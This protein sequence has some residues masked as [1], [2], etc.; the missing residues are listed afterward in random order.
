MFGLSKKKGGYTPADI[1]KK[2]LDLNKYRETL[3][4]GESDK[5]AK[6]SAER[7]LQNII[8]KLGALAVAQESKKGFPQGIPAVAR[9]YMEAYGIEEQ[10]LVPQ[11]PN[12][13]MGQPSPMQS[14]VEEVPET[15]GEQEDMADMS[16]EMQQQAPQ[17][18]PPE[19]QQQMMQQEQPT[20]AMYGAIMGGYDMPF[21]YAYGGFPKFAPGG[22]TPYERARTAAGNVTPTGSDNKYS[23]T[24]VPLAQHLADWEQYIPGVSNMSDGDAQKAMYEWSLKNNPDV[25]RQMWKARGI[26][27]EGRKYSDLMGLTQNGTG[28]FDDATLA[29]IDNLKALERAYVDKKFGIRQLQPVMAP[30]PNVPPGT[31]PNTPPGTP[32]GTPPS[33]PEK[34][35]V[36]PDPNDPTKEIVKPVGPDGK[37][38]C[39]TYEDV[40]T[41]DTTD[42]DEPPMR[43]VAKYFPED[44]L[45]MMATLGYRAPKKDPIYVGPRGTQFELTG[46]DPRSAV[47][48]AYAG[49][50]SATDA[51]S[52]MAAS[53]PAAL[54]SG[55]YQAQKQ[56]AQTSKQAFDQANQLNVGTRSQEVMGN[57]NMRKDLLDKIPVYQLDYD[58]KVA[59][60]A[61][62]KAKFHNEKLKAFVDTNTQRG[63]NA[64]DLAMVNAQSENF[65][66]DP[67]S[68]EMIKKQGR[69][70]KYDPKTN[71]QIASRTK[72][73]IN[74]GI[75]DNKVAYQIAQSELAA[76]YGGQFA[77]GGSYVYG[78]TVFPFLF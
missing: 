59:N 69:A 73:L 63:Q 23:S 52:K 11:D 43:E 62:N 32:P 34:E 65:S 57:T 14:G 44:T 49:A 2:Y 56:A 46:V 42:I 67:V 31:P 74:S 30:P 66:Y 58:N 68:R 70:F 53:N 3:Q 33:P 29:N 76:A 20:M 1:S 54:L 7:M 36:C 78:D 39:E 35:C 19:M 72:E 45:R 40:E 75:T 60:Q 10:D 77:R 50:N 12:A 9:P 61:L 55:S 38:P 26:T 71:S 64:L 4:S 51:Y 48:A 27:N 8:I 6:A 5:I 16:S 18:M 15:Q 22:P 24:G 21:E 28:T 13:M 37:C 25:I 41:T 17:Q 47:N